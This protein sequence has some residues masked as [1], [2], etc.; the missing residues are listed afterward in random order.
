MQV[1]ILHILKKL[2][3]NLSHCVKT[4]G[5]FSKTVQTFAPPT[6]IYVVYETYLITELH[7]SGIM[8]S[9]FTG[10]KTVL[11]ECLIVSHVQE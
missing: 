6:I 2:H 10:P 1:D 4:E 8:T 3:E 9:P 7:K 5:V 11:L